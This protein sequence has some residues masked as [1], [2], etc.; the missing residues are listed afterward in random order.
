M[1][2]R[3]L[4]LGSNGSGQLGIGHSNDTSGPEQCIFHGSETADKIEKVTKIVGGGNHTLV[5]SSK[6][7]VWAAGRNDDGRCGLPATTERLETFQQIDVGGVVTHVAATWEA[8]VFVVDKRVV[9]TCGTGLK[10]ELGQGPD[11][12]K[13]P[14][15][16]QVV[17]EDDALLQGAEVL[18][19]VAGVNPILLLMSNGDVFGWGTSRRGQLGEEAKGDKVVWKPRK[20]NIA[21]GVRKITAGRNFSYIIGC[22]NEQRL[23]GDA[24]HFTKGMALPLGEDEGAT[25]S[26]WSDIY[27][28]SPSGVYSVGRNDRGQLCPPSLPPLKHF[29]AGSEHCV[30]CTYDDKIIAWGWGEHGNCGR[31]VDD[32]RGDVV[33]EYNTIPVSL[34]DDETVSGVAAGCATSF[35]MFHRP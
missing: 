29:A 5:L 6:G 10:G 7:R 33:G 9:L 34:Q 24:K 23:L 26:G 27:Y 17:M 30:G 11:V 12:T 25:M 20:I 19:V 16:K 1:P 31:P 18:D 13:S 28:H 3:I 21:F 8:S 2:F 14:V 35:V 15:M 4:A 32:E 22:N